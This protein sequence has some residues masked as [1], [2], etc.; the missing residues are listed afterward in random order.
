MVD[1]FWRSKGMRFM[2]RVIFCFLRFLRFAFIYIKR[3]LPPAAKHPRDCFH[4]SGGPCE[5]KQQLFWLSFPN[6]ST[7][8]TQ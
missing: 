2:M 8:K 7:E 1:L 3:Y 4:L 6:Q 5:Y